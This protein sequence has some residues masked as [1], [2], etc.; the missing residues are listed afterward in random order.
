MDNFLYLDSVNILH[1]ASFI[2][3]GLWGVKIFINL[4]FQIIQNT[5]MT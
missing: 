2:S 3:G 5:L 4:T 1:M